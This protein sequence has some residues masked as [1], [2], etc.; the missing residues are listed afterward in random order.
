MYDVRV[1]LVIANKTRSVQYVPSEEVLAEILGH[2]DLDGEDWKVGDRIIFED[3]TE[4][5]I[6]RAS[7]GPFYVWDDSTF[8]DLDDVKQAAGRSDVKSWEQLF[9]AFRDAPNAIRDPSVP[10]RTAFS[11]P[12]AAALLLGLVGVLLLLF[13]R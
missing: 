13:R 6:Q 4:A 9:A 11:W 10:G 1:P 8:A 12:L 3:G 7:E 2:S 5:R